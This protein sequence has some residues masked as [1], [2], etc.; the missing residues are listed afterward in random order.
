[1]YDCLFVLVLLKN[2]VRLII[3]HSDVIIKRAMPLGIYPQELDF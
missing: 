1:M 3:L 2:Y